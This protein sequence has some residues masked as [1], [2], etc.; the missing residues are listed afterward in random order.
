[1]ELKD[2]SKEG[3]NHIK[4]SPICGLEEH[5]AI[6]CLGYVILGTHNFTPEEL[7]SYQAMAKKFCSMEMDLMMCKAKFHDLLRDYN[8][9]EVIR[10]CIEVIR[11]KYRETVFAWIIDGVSAD[12]HYTYDEEDYI[13]LLR[14]I[15]GI[16]LS[17]VETIMEVMSIK[18]KKY[19]P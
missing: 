7:I 2:S 18:N 3:A 10:D 9:S 19:R 12:D 6:M 5:E 16:P 15:I 17:K 13:T 4:K 8:N 14:E 1:M 11:P